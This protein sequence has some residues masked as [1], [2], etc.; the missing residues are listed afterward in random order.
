VDWSKNP[1]HLDLKLNVE[2][3]AAQTIMEFIEPGIL[4]IGW[5][6]RD[7]ARPK[8][9]TDE[10]IVLTRMEN[11]PPGSKQAK[12]DAD[13][14]TK[15]AEFYQ[16]TGKF[17]TAYFYYQLVQIRY[18]GTDFAE[19]ARQALED[20]KKHRTR[21]VDGSEVWGPPGQPLQ[22]P[23]PPMNQKAP[24]QLPPPPMSQEAPKAKTPPLPQ[25]APTPNDENPTPRKVAER[26]ARVGRIIIV[27][28]TKTEDG[29]I[30]KILRLHP[31]DVIDYEA[32]RT[33][34]KNLA[35]LKARIDLIESVDNPDYK[36]IRV[37]VVE[38]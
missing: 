37:T 11:H 12:Q 27:G 5:G 9:F 35:A 23:P 2:M 13:R 14:E 19:K 4:R 21:L 32:L 38:K 3:P 16:R 17:S 29:A 26:A 22:P 30:R 8:D 7:E 28:N 33:A 10:T 1:H 31:G 15:V 18:P 25:T 36:D 34:E 20:L 6:G 24:K